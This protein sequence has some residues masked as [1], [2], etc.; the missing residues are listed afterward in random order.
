MPG[1]VSTAP[2]RSDIKPSK[3]TKFNANATLAITP[4]VRYQKVINNKVK[5]MPMVNALIPCSILSSPRVASMLRCFTI[6]TGAV[7]DPARNNKAS[8]CAACGLDML[9]ILNC[10]PKCCWIV[11]TLM[12]LLFLTISSFASR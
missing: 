11:A 7:N 2:G 3:L 8:S 10:E 4:K 1:S 9:V 5:E 6:V 12:T